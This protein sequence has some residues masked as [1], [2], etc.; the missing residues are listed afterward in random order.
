VTGAVHGRLR[1][2]WMIRSP[3]T[4]SNG[5]YDSKLLGGLQIDDEIEPGGALDG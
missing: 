3:V 1:P 4:A 2:Y 5:D